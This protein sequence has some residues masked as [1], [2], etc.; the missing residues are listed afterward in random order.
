MS[1]NIDKTNEMFIFVMIYA[2]Y[3]H[4][5]KKLSLSE[6]INYLKNKDDVLDELLN[7]SIKLKQIIFE[8]VEESF[9]ETEQDYFDFN[10][11]YTLNS[12]YIYHVFYNI[13]ED[14][15]EEDKY[16]FLFL[17]DIKESNLKKSNIL[18]YK[19]S[20]L[21]F[22]INSKNNYYFVTSP[23]IEKYLKLMHN[24]MNIVFNKKT[25]FILSNIREFMLNHD[26]IQ[27]DINIAILRNDRDFLLTKKESQNLAENSDIYQGNSLVTILL[28]E[29]LIKSNDKLLFIVNN[30]ILYHKY[31]KNLREFMSP[32]INKII[33]N[34]L[35]SIIF[36]NKSVPSNEIEFIIYIYEKQKLNEKLT[37]LKNINIK[38]EIYIKN[39]KII[40]KKNYILFNDFFED[41]E[42]YIFLENI[43]NVKKSQAIKNDE[44]GKKIY[45]LKPT[46]NNLDMLMIDNIDFFE[47]EEKISKKNIENYTLYPND[48]LIV[49][50]GKIAVLYNYNIDYDNIIP[51][52]SFALLRFKNIDLAKAYYIYLISDNGQKQLQKLQNNNIIPISNLKKL[53]LP[54]LTDTQ[55]ND[56]IHIFDYIKEYN[57]Q[58]S[59]IKQNI[60]NSIKGLYN[61]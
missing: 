14:V 26:N 30:N 49:I 21:S 52:S 7:W 44:K 2:D 29:T 33:H 38:K 50:K 20:L 24:I 32:Y 59:K 45:I 34:N 8:L 25:N 56:A 22:F 27:D 57:T 9:N 28:L 13:F 5:S 36:I 43:C 12:R 16:D 39:K 11:E 4:K 54:N 53:Q 46:F 61:G 47:T 35:T 41:K 31:Y 3:I 55:I 40:E 15:V 58:C 23:K 18:S 48:I 19:P 51:S 10:N 42:N 60:L 37:N 1:K 17:D 6:T